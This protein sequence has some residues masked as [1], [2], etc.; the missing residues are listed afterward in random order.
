VG[1]DNLDGQDGDDVL[2]GGDGADVLIGGGGD[3]LMTGGK[4]QDRFEFGDGAGDDRI[5]DFAKR[6]MVA[7][8]AAGIDD[9]S[10]LTIASDSSGNAVISWGTGDSITLDGYKAKKLSAADFDFGEPTAARLASTDTGSFDDSSFR[11]LIVAD[12]WLL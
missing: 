8:D 9:F 6:D 12:G 7:I 11:A 4:G 3:D 1:D 5:T 10:N 2:D